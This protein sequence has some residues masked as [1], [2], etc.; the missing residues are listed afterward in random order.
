[1]LLTIIKHGK[2]YKVKLGHTMQ[3]ITFTFTIHY[4]SNG[5]LKFS[6]F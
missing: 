6:D 5:F 2:E 1:M 4:S 3:L